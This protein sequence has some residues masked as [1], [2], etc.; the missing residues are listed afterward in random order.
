MR[1]P[2]VLAI[3]RL[4]REREHA[5]E[6]RG[7]LVAPPELQR[8]QREVVLGERPPGVRRGGHE[9]VGARDERRRLVAAA[10]VDLDERQPRQ[11]L[12]H[13]AGRARPL[14]H[15]ERRAAVLGRAVH[16]AERRPHLHPLLGRQRHANLQVRLA[17]EA[18]GLGPQLGRALEVAEVAL[19]LREAED[20]AR[21][22]ADVGDPLRER[23]GL[24][25][26]LEPLV[27]AP[28]AQERRRAR[29]VGADL[30]AGVVGAPGRVDG[31]GQQVERRLGAAPLAGVAARD[32]EDQG[33]AAPA[34]RPR[35]GQG[36]VEPRGGLVG[37]PAVAREG[38]QQAQRLD[39]DRLQAGVVRQVARAAG[40]GL[41]RVEVRVA[42]LDDAPEQLD[43]CL[44]VPVPRLLEPRVGPGQRRQRLGRAALANQAFGPVH[45]RV[46]LRRPGAP[47]GLLT[48]RRHGGRDEQGGEAG[49]RQRQRQA[50]H[51]S[52][53]GRQISTLSF[54][55]RFPW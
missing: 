2:L 54:P 35:E 25:R 7:G 33:V 52:E 28:E 45:E 13:R 51:G 49:Q 36:L 24:L 5:R 41:G 22:Q 10:A 43:P 37:A 30:G 4:A 11:R 38:R 32:L 55:W 44:A 23:V 20:R 31:P 42:P 21:L 53:D 50:V 47:R 17:V 27:E 6:A 18:D 8:R 26:V 29:A 34:R 48:G 14:V 1:A 15:R 46:G 19:G 9:R 39:L 40:V 3:G 12:G 16:V